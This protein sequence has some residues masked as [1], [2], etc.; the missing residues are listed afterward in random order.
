[1]SYSPA[2]QLRPVGQ[3]APKTDPVI[4][5]IMVAG[6][7]GTAAAMLY[8]ERAEKRRSE[9]SWA[10]HYDR[11]RLRKNRSRRKVAQRLRRRRK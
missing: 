11:K 9:A 10:T 1:V 4:I 6:V 2:L 8:L 7:L 5:A 3:D